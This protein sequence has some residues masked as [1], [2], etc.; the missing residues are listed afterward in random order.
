VQQSFSFHLL[1]A[2]PDFNHNLVSL[3]TTEVREKTMALKNVINFYAATSRV[4]V[5]QFT[6]V[7]PAEPT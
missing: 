3:Q 2:E 6:A 5:V 1:T 4:K 7:G